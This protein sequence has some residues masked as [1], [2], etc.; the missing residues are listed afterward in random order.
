MPTPV[1][2]FTPI[3]SWVASS[4]VG[5]VSFSS[6]DQGYDHLVITGGFTRNINGDFGGRSAEFQWNG[7]G[8]GYKVLNGYVGQGTATAQAQ[9]IS[10]A[11][12]GPAVPAGN[13]NYQ[14]GRQAFEIWVT[15]YKNTA[16]YKHAFGKYTNNDT[17]ANSGGT[18][19]ISSTLIPTTSAL[20]SLYIY[21]QVDSF[22]AGDWL[23]IYGVKNA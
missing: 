3:H 15:D 19:W 4:N 9:F 14:G 13:A 22:V 1:Q 20:T 11:A 5:S 16:W 21:E 7:I 6:I 2:T 10:N 17:N 23:T 8:S 12:S 18:I